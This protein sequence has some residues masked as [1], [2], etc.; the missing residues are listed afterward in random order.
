MNGPT[1]KRVTSAVYLCA[2]CQAVFG[3]SPESGT[4]APVVDSQAESARMQQSKGANNSRK[5]EIPDQYRQYVR[6]N[7]KTLEL[8]LANGEVLKLVDQP[9]GPKADHS[10]VVRYVFQNFYPSIDYF[11]VGTAFSE[12]FEYALISRKSGKVISIDSAPIWSPKFDRLVTTSFCDLGCRSR[13]QIWRVAETHLKLEWNFTPE[14]NWSAPRA[15]WLDDSTIVISGE[16]VGSAFSVPGESRNVV[17]RNTVNLKHLA[18][19][20]HFVEH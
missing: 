18:E 7:G 10:R 19:G 9:D 16:N 11:L 2:S 3:F 17:N 8:T 1:F 15:R 5:T 20:W 4:S 14:Q 13:L 6:R 12:E